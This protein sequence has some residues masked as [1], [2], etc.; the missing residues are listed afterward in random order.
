MTHSSAVIIGGGIGGLFT[1]AILARNGVSV[2]V[3]EKNGIIGGGLQCFTRQN[4]I[5]ETGMHVM[6][7]F[8]P[9]GS[10]H[11]ICIYLDILHRLSIHHIS[12]E[13]MDEI[14]FD[15]TG[16]RYLIPSGRE[17]F[18]ARMARYFPAEAEGIRAYVDKIYSLTEEVPMFYLREHTPNPMQPHSEEFLWSADRLIAHYVADPRLREI[19]AYLNPLYGGVEGHTPAYIHAL[20]NVLY[21]NGASRFIGG[22]QQLADALRGVI[23]A[24]GGAVIA[25]CEVSEIAVTDKRVEHVT[26]A[27]GRRFTADHYISSVHPTEML[28][29]LPSNPFTRIFTSRLKKIPNSYSAF[30][31]YID[32]KP[33]AMPYIDHTCYYTA[34]YGAMWKQREFDPADWPRGFMYMTP[35]DPEQGRYASRM[36]VHC[37]MD[38]NCVAPWE[39][40]TVGHR[41]ADYEAWKR[42]CADRVIEKLGRVIPGFADMVSRVYSASP[43]TVRDYYHTPRGAIF[44]YMKDCHNYLYSQLSVFTKV[45]NL[46][47]TGQNINLHGICGVPLTA[48]NTAEAI[49]GQNFVIKQINDSYNK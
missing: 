25:G 11:K 5:Y 49:L 20:I 48:V 41:G 8:E 4:K 16:E 3:L 2:T 17:A 7:G 14:C 27:D 44:G 38:Y 33:E 42:R 13:C 19:L 37:I 45:S 6:G 26:T 24:H 39:H 46:Y 29:L 47:L 31:L 21:I 1:G 35:P 23:E 18:T 36:L 32:L 34:D 10:L 9:G 28:R 15:A 22:S 12:P 30:S 40:T 43:L